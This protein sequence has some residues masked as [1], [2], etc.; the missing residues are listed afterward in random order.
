V[1]DDEGSSEHE[2]TNRGGIHKN[3]YGKLTTEQGNLTDGES[4]V[5]ATSLF[6]LVRSAAFYI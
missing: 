4:S 3:S 1:D 6:Q 2:W 5:Q